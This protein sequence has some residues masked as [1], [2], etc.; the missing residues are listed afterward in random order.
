MDSKKKKKKCAFTCH[1]AGG[2]RKA[3][4]VTVN[5][6]SARWRIKCYCCSTHVDEPHIQILV[7]FMGERGWIS[8]VVRS[9]LSH[10]QKRMKESFCVRREKKKSVRTMDLHSLPA[11]MELLSIISIIRH[12]GLCGLFVP[13]LQKAASEAHHVT[14]RES[15]VCSRHNVV[16]P[17]PEPHYRKMS[18]RL[19]LLQLSIQTWRRFLCCD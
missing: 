10:M 12:N 19:V 4:N 7:I 5:S 3:S 11:I 14:V 8:R 6:R 17:E 15:T 1:C 18:K 9:T 13:P 16:Q 2:S